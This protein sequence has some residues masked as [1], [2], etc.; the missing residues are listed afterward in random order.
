MIK[1]Y[2]MPTC[3]DC[4]AVDK[5]V[6]NNPNYEIIDIGSHVRN[7]KAFLQLRD[8]RPEFDRLKK[9]GDV[10]IPCF[11]MEDGSITF[12]PAEAGIDLSAA[13]KPQGASCK[14]DGSGC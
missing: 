6:E 3:P 5:V 1:I 2:G 10:C 7:L 11:V 13:E 4:Q 12:D 8:N 14:I 9:Q